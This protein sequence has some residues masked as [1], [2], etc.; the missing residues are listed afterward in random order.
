MRRI[1][2]IDNSN[3]HMEIKYDVYAQGVMLKTEETR[4]NL[5]ER[6]SDHIFKEILKTRAEKRGQ[7]EKCV[8]SRCTGG[9]ECMRDEYYYNR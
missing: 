5:G 9:S 1:V 7:S 6:E 8:V 3:Y 2:R 4:Y